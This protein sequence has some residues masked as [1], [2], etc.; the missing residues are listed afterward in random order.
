MGPSSENEHL[1]TFWVAGE[2]R[3]NNDSIAQRIFYSTLQV[4]EMLGV[5]PVS[6]RR[7]L[8]AGKLRATCIGGKLR[9]DAEAIQEFIE[10]GT[11]DYI[12]KNCIDLSRGRTPRQRRDA[13][14]RAASKL[15][16]KSADVQDV[17]GTAK[18]QFKK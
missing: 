13:A 5:H 12:R 10:R 16:V 9:V 17:D 18:P 7:W 2:Y 6:V 8:R 3:V 14:D 1:D 4:A 11:D 15:G